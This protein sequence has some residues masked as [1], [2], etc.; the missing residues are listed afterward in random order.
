MAT[1]SHP[2]RSPSVAAVRE[3]LDGVTDPELDRSIVELDYIE[4]IT[5]DGSHV[6]VIFVLPTAWCSPAFAWMMAVD[7]RDEIEALPSV[8]RAEITLEEHLH[9]EEIT[10][11]V[12]D[13]QSFEETFPDAEGGVAGVRATLDA[14]A[15]LARQY[16]AVEMLLKAGLDGEQIASLERRHLSLDD[17]AT[18]SLREES[19]V[20]P[21]EADPIEAYLEKAEAVGLTDDE[22]SKLF[23]TPE[24]EPID[25]DDFELVHNRTRLASTNMT[26]QGTICDALNE[27]RHAEDR[28]PLHPE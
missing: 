8:D 12:N 18:V 9:E 22:H 7:A 15:R 4:D 3:Q 2:D 24:S 27:A 25:P 5:I 10:R 21:V 16:D 28:P 20:V 23:R 1:S 13:R 11:G 17:P 14:K 19:V 6:S 26:G